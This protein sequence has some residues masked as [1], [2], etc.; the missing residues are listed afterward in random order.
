MQKSLNSLLFLIQI[1]YDRLS[2]VQSTS[3]KHIDIVMVAHA[4]QKFKAIWSYIEL[5]LVSFA[6][7]PDISLFVGEN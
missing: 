7:K 5:E 3:R 2:V 6:C 4:S 1:S